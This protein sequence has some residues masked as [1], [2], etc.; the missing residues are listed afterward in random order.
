VLVSE[1]MLQQ[2]QVDRV[3]ATFR[4]FMERFPSL[5][6]LAATSTDEA[7]SAFS[8]LGYYRRARLLH[9]AACA[10]AQR[11]SWPSSAR[12]LAGLPGFGPY[13][14]AAVAA[15]SFNGPDPPVDGNVAR[16]TARMQA[17]ELPMGSSALLRRGREFAA[18]LH[19][20][21][22]TPEVWE[23][24]IELGATVC[25]P[26]APHCDDCPLAAGCQALA[27]RNPHAYPRPRPKRSRE[28]HRWVALWLE[29]VDGRVLLR[30]VQ[31][32]PLLVGLWLPP[33]AALLDGADPASAAEAL[34]EEA[35]FAG[36]LAPAPAVRHGITHRNIRVLPFM[37][38][39]PANRAS[40]PRPGWRW[41]DPGSPDL[42][43][44]S[45]LAKLA[46]ACKRV[47]TPEVG[48]QEG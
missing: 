46:E 33:F 32:G 48:D 9:A 18:S 17:L 16:V 45:L 4:R 10:V 19:A 5:E 8:G 11:G 23:A 35:A 13:T 21:C 28:E 6:A 20:D 3:V 31:D 1:V 34:A 37:A 41:C 36:P 29:R 26:A 40:E 30:C 25:T 22:P 24:L 7:V 15:F 2:T 43:T 39:M 12:E 47:H 14:G 38:R 44:S 42:P 27:K